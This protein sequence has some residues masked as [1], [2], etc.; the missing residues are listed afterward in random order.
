MAYTTV[1]LAKK[2]NRIENAVQSDVVGYDLARVAK[3]GM[4]KYTPVDTGRMRN[5]ATIQPWLIKYGVPYA[6]YPYSG[7][8][9]K[10]HREKNPNAT[11]HWPET[12]EKASGDD[13]Y[14]AAEEIIK[15]RV[16]QV[17]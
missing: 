15:T 9:G 6:Y 14:R 4:D 3:K 7:R 11:A 8:Y 1:G 17:G 12:W 2:L 10:I 5:T 16:R 13:F